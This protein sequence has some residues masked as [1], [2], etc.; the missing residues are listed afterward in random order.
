MQ[1]PTPELQPRP[2]VTDLMVGPRPQAHYEPFQMN[3][4]TTVDEAYVYNSIV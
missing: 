3:A 2:P 1:A 4:T